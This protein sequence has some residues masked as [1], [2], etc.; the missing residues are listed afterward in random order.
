MAANEAA[1]AKGAWA[2]GADAKAEFLARAEKT[3]AAGGISDAAQRL[4][5]KHLRKAIAAFRRADYAKSAMLAVDATGAD[6]K[7][8]QAFHMLA[9]SL[10][11][12][13]EIG[14]AMEMYERA[15]QLDPTDTDLYLNL[16][17]AAWRMDLHQVAEK[18]FRLACEMA[19]GTPMGWNN[20]AGVLRDQ[21]RFD[22]AIEICRDAIYRMPEQ[23]LLW[24]TLGTI[25]VE[26][27]DFGQAATFYREALRLDPNFTR[28]WHNLG[29]GLHHTGPL[30]E[31]LAAYETAMSLHQEPRDRLETEH[32]K[33][34][35]LIA[36]GR[37]AEGFAAYE[38]RHHHQHRASML[39]GI[40]APFWKGE[41][42]AGKSV[43]VMGEQGL[44]DE[45]M[46]ANTLPDIA[47]AIGPAGQLKIAV[48]SRMRTLFA[49]S[50]PTAEVGNYFVA[51]H[52]GKDLRLAPWA[53]KPDYVLPL[54]SALPQ[55]RKTLDAFPGKAFLTPD[56][57][58]VAEMR[59]ALPQDGRVIVG[60]CWR[61]MM[62]N[63]HRQKYF[64]AIDLWAP[65]LKTPNVAFVNLQYGDA[66]AEIARAHEL[67]GVTIHQ[68]EGLDLKN[69]LEG[70]AALSA[71]CDLAIS[72]PTAAAAMAGAVGTEI[73]F[74]TAGPVWPQ[75]GTDHYPWYRASH[76]YSPAAF[77]DWSGII[78][79]VAADLA[80]RA[81]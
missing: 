75:L 60:I 36:M 49:R 51:K 43:L 73:W 21:S 39:Y 31:A 20:L 8:G 35:C 1:E 64:S 61:S 41:D 52:N 24:N 26:L 46:F 70:A 42:L 72:A 11:H 74:L 44:G 18:F 37:L 14:R 30:E 32:A 62:I 65:I 55:L 68:V 50:F 9:L 16:G 76:V 53:G 33:A 7:S 66:S 10:D 77:G 6:P 38:V 58:R 71:A 22:E 47:A 56:Q 79:R 63:A 78:P 5:H 54:G 67:F 17:L 19:P 40:D 23:P 13:G 27:S 28:A 80:Y 81:P 69:D 25:L 15:F 2:T 48:D 4:C 34:L 57:A 59:A 12:L 3:T 45:V 29:Y